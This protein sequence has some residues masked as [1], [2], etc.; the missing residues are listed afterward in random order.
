[1]S[2]ILSAALEKQ[3]RVVES[4]SVLRVHYGPLSSRSASGVS[5]HSGSVRE[6]EYHWIRAHRRPGPEGSAGLSLTFFE[7]KN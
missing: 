1:M 2:S 4:R 5:G 6:T 7:L 3:R